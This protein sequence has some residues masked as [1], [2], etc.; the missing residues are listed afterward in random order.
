MNVLT[1]AK[2][3]RLSSEDDDMK[4][5]G[6]LE[7]NSIANQ[8]NLLN[9]YISRTPELSGA[10]V[11]E[12]CDDGWSGRNFERPGIQKLLDSVRQGKI[13]CI[14]VK[15]LS[16]FG[17]DYLEVGNYISRVFPFMGVRFISVND[18]FDSINPLDID[19]LETSFKTLLYD[20]YSRDLSRKVKS[21]KMMQA[22]RG[23][24]L[25][26]FAPYGY[27]K[28]PDNHNHLLIDPDA[29]DTVRTIFRMMGDGNSAEQIA[30]HLNHLAIPTPMRLKHSAGCS[31][32]WP[33]I[34]E[35][36]FWTDSTVSVILRDQRYIGNN[37]YGKRTRDRVGH[38]HSVKVSREDWVVAKDTHEG[39]VTPEEFERAQASMRRLCEREWR[40]PVEGQVLKKKVR[41]G[42]CGHIM[43]RSKANEAAYHCRTPRVT[44]AWSCPTESVSERDILE[45]VTQGLRVQAETAVEMGQIWDEI[46]C[47][48]KKDRTTL[49]KA[50]TTLQAEQARQEQ[51]SST[52]YE[53]LVMGEISTEKYLAAKASL[54]QAKEKTAER[55]AVLEAEINNMNQDGGLDN[56][57][58]EAFGKYSNVEWLSEEMVTEVLD[59]ILVYPDH[60]LEI[61]WKFQDDF[62]KLATELSGSPAQ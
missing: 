29:A 5:V 46:H 27:I 56:R 33:C 21:A 42:I 40:G 2:Y 19:S 51:E 22:K 1:V 55:T 11:L 13:G 18:G 32:A 49:R 10:E 50:L 16:R 61:V 14:I 53:S 4:T 3:L 15:D 62:K 38:Y 57:F 26:P 17:R 45:M 31:R 20:L 36:N 25:S 52:L 7:S 23:L 9:S 54:K 59:S 8:R 43:A 30:R 48:K 12:F 28:D 34:R 6:K 60:R 41:C 47:R 35:D 44:D 37:V 39:I 58:I 24:F